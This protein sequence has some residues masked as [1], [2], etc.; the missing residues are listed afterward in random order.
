MT[1][2]VYRCS[3]HTPSKVQWHLCHADTALQLNKPTH[4]SI[5]WPCRSTTHLQGCL[6]VLV[7]SL[8]ERMSSKCSVLWLTQD[9][10]QKC[11]CAWLHSTV[12]KYNS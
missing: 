6:E 9:W 5:V 4:H 10:D 2:L 3:Y 1:N 12:C 7:V 8:A 11:W